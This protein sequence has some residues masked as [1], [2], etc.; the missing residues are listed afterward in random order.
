M[1]MKDGEWRSA[2]SLPCW[3]F[4]LQGDLEVERWGLLSP[5]AVAALPEYFQYLRNQGS[6]V[7]QKGKKSLCVYCRSWQKC[8]FQPSSS[9]APRKLRRWSTCCFPGGRALLY[10]ISSI[11]LNSVWKNVNTKLAPCKSYFLSS[12]AA[13]DRQENI[14]LNNLASSPD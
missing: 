6:Q 13:G 4:S 12:E 10:L 8:L 7:Q 2:P 11:P 14:S 1:I 3:K 5:N 9:A